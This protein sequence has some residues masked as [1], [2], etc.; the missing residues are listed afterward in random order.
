MYEGDAPLEP[1]PEWHNDDLIRAAM[2]LPKAEWNLVDLAKE[3]HLGPFGAKKLEVSLKIFQG[4]GYRIRTEPA[5]ELKRKKAKSETAH[6][7]ETEET[8]EGSSSMRP[9]A[10]KAPGK[11]SKEAAPSKCG[12][13]HAPGIERHA[14]G[15]WLCKA[16]V[17]AG[18][19]CAECN[20]PIVKAADREARKKERESDF[21]RL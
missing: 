12:S 10:P 2:D 7:D 14:C 18:G 20:A 1:T 6:E 21:S 16:C 5:P 3:L 17:D 13:H 9:D 8:G 11:D 19:T 4:G 15:A